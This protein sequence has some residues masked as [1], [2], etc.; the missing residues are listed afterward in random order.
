M[1]VQLNDATADIGTTTNLVQGNSDRCVC[2]WCQV[3]PVVTGAD[4]VTPWEIDNGAGAYE[5][6]FGFDSGG[7]SQDRYAINA[8]NGGGASISPDLNILVANSFHVGYRKFGTTLQLLINGFIVGTCTEDMSLVVYTAMRIGNDGFSTV[9]PGVRIWDFKEWSNSKSV[10][11]VRT[12]MATYGAVAS[13]SGLQRFCPLVNDLLDD[14]GN[15]FDLTGAGNF[16]FVANP[17]LPPNVSAATAIDVTALPFTASLESYN[18]PLWYKR[19]AAA[20]DTY[21][22]GWGFGGLGTYEPT[23]FIWA[24]DGTVPWPDTSWQVIAVNKPYEFPVVPGEVYYHEYRSQF[25]GAFGTLD[26]SLLPE[27]NES[28]PI[29]N[30]FFVTDDSPGFGASIIDSDDGHVYQ[31]RYPGY[32]AG[33]AGEDLPEGSKRILLVS[34]VIGDDPSLFTNELWFYEPD[35][36]PITQ[37]ARGADAITGATSNKVDTF[38]VVYNPAGAVDGYVRR[39]TEAGVLLAGTIG[40]LTG[41]TAVINGLAVSPAESILYWQQQGN[42]NGAIHRWDIVNNVAL[43]DLVASP[44]AGWFGLGALITLPDGDVIGGFD[45]FLSGA[46]GH[47]RRY[48]A[49]DGSTVWSYDTGVLA[50]DYHGAKLAY[51]FDWPDSIYLIVHFLNGHSRFI[52]LATDDGAVINT[53]DVP[54]YSIGVYDPAESATPEARFGP[55]PSCTYIMLRAGVTPPACPGLLGAPRIGI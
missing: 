39:Y 36:T 20:E 6:V 17:A 46:G 49:V 16:S 23:A 8:D 5:G 54:T 38:Y 50:I 41:G 25:G 13:P 40:P 10:G 29:G 15:G 31:F 14:S 44:G 47:L 19:T 48:S 52:N 51:G 2:F 28:A 7:G 30:S 26:V 1:A 34:D 37:V 11:T 9:A 42:N 43:A 21:T 27:P 35:L 55:A 12:E 4:Y 45:Q 53:L 33:N 22:G 24:D 32:P 3:D 18:L